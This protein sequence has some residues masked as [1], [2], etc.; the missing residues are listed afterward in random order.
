MYGIPATEENGNGWEIFPVLAHSF[1]L[2]TTRWWWLSSMIE[3]FVSSPVQETDALMA[4]RWKGLRQTPSAFF[5]A[6]SFLPL[7]I[8]PPLPLLSFLLCLHVT[9][10]IHS[11]VILVRWMNSMTMMTLQ[12]NKVF[13]LSSPRERCPDAFFIALSFFPLLIIPPLSLL[14]F[15]LSLH[16]F[17]ILV[18]WMNSMTMMTL[19]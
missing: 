16:S 13:C 7:L 6:L 5:I 11:F 18:R 2:H 3:F 19:Q 1:I 15:L 4:D 17:V 8:I 12:Y 10:Y 9:C 14:S